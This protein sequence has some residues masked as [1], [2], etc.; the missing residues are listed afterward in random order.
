MS[1]H[2][3]IKAS[4]H[5]SP[6]HW[7]PKMHCYRAELAPNL[8]EGHVMWEVK[9]NAKIQRIS[10]MRAASHQIWIPFKILA[11][12]K[13]GRRQTRFLSRTLIQ[14]NAEVLPL[15]RPVPPHHLPG[16]NTKFSFC[17]TLPS[18]A[19]KGCQGVYF[20]ASESNCAC[21][22]DILIV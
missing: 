2:A 12:L 22:G 17:G 21:Q 5:Q 3:K 4:F 9:G 15:K 19:I 8:D 14:M 16:V 20:H 7:P 13:N 6:H 11:I 10:L 1:D 18:R